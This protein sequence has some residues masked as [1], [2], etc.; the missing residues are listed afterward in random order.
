MSKIFISA[1]DIRPDKIVCLAAQELQIVNQGK[2]LQL[3]GFGTSK[4][5]TDCTNPF[6]LDKNFRQ[7]QKLETFLA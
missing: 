1:I 3:I 2:I 4:F 7:S 5:P 6:Y